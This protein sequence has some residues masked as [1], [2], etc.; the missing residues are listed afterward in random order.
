MNEAPTRRRKGNPYLIPAKSR[1]GRIRRAVSRCFIL[2]NGEPITTRA[3]L[4]RAYP[5]ERRFKTWHYLGAYLA[6]RK[7]ALAVARKRHGRGR[8]ALWAKAE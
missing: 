4:E 7:V 5:R 2:S 6:L 8:P 1:M 3:V